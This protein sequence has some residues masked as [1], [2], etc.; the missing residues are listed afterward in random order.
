MAVDQE[1]INHRFHFEAVPLQGNGGRP[2][3]EAV[4]SRSEAACELGRIIA[5][6]KAMREILDV[7]RK[8]AAPD[9]PVLIYGEPDTG[10]KL[11]ACEMHRQSR[12]Q[13]GPLVHVVCG[14]LRESDL[15]EKLFGTARTAH[16]EA[17]RHSCLLWSKPAEGLCTW[18]TSC[19][20]RFGVRSGCWRSCSR[21]EMPA[22][23]DLR[24]RQST[25]E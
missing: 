15:A 12:R 16:G 24:A 23:P 5:A 14:G 20:C 1:I 17:A 8:S 19:S 11:I 7:V 22:A 3:A 13:T 4:G 21:G 9:A 18:K 25:C 6:S 2:G 10:K